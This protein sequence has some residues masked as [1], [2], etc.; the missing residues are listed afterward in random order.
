[1]KMLNNRPFET[2]L[3]LELQSL[4]FEQQL[5]FVPGRG[6]LQKDWAMSDDKQLKTAAL[7]TV[8]TTF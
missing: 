5:T 3:W 4:E 6:V 1:M 2:K 8:V 7:E